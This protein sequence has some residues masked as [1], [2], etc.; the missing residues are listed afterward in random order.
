MVISAETVK[1]FCIH[2]KLNL[3]FKRTFILL[4]FPTFLGLSTTSSQAQITVVNERSINTAFQEYSP[5]F[6]DKGLVFI[7]SNPAV[8]KDKKEDA[9]LGQSTTSVFYAKRSNDGI[10]QRP[11]PFADELT[12]KFYDGPLSFNAAGDVVFFT[13]TNLRKGKL[14]VGRDG[15]VKLKIYSAKLNVSKGIWDNIEELPFNSNNFDCMHPSVS[16]DGQQL[17][18]ASNR[19]GG[20]GGL[21]LYVSFMQKGKWGAPINLGK[22][23]NTPQNEVFPFI[24]R[25]NTLYFATNGRKAVGGFDIFWTKKNVDIWLAPTAM[26]E[27]INSPSDDFGIILTEDKRSGFFSSN[28][29]SGQGDDDIFSFIDASVDIRTLKNKMNSD[30]IQEKTKQTKREEV[31]NQA[32]TSNKKSE[33]EGSGHEDGMSNQTKSQRQNVVYVNRNIENSKTVIVEIST[34][35]KATNLPIPDVKVSIINMESIKN[36]TFMTD[37]EGNVRGLRAESGAEI[38]IDILPS[39]E[40]VSDINGIVT[41]AAQVGERFIFNFLKHEYH[42]KYVVKTVAKGDSRVAAFM[43]KPYAKSVLVNTKGL[44]LQNDTLPTPNLSVGETGWNDGKHGDYDFEEPQYEMIDE[45]IVN[46]YKFEMRNIYYGVGDAE[47]NEEAK[48]ELAPLLKIMLNDPKVDIEIASHTDSNGKTAFNMSLSQLRADNIKTFF[49]EKGISPDRIR[50]FGYGETMIRNH[51]KRGV[52][53]SEEEHAQNRRTVIKIVK[54]V[55][56]QPIVVAEKPSKQAI[57]PSKAFYTE[58]GDFTAVDTQQTNNLTATTPP[59]TRFYVVIGT[60]TKAENAIKQQ[61]K[62]IDAGFVD[63][64]VVQYQDSQLYGVS[65]RVLN[66]L[67][68]AHKLMDGIN[69]QKIFEAF[70]KELK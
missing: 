30:E 33:W 44:R 19:P 25:D 57:K 5:A 36:A 59:N 39:Q 53:C 17:Y 38:P 51:C 1:R 64:K 52:K 15:K 9:Q 10:F 4:L 27:P 32:P 66:D 45:P 14:K 34:I 65:V 18:F 70:V 29:A 47:V 28:R 54:G 31:P 2:L 55:E 22:S 58:G 40:V 67:N 68:E 16:V 8:N 63:A 43:V 20:N 50:A 11:V 60:Y 62:A 42:S 3:M 21:D 24:H 41:V 23:I 48:M 37:A 7:A 26:P 35:D 13:R 56:T 6:Y 12:T 49:V 46:N 61:K 69:S